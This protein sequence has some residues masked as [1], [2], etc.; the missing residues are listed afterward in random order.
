[1][2]V[3]EAGW[4]LAFGSVKKRLLTSWWIILQRLALYTLMKSSYA[5]QLASI[6]PGKNDTFCQ[7][8]I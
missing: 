3:S 7:L 8:A 2:K 5:T 6:K 1:M 4:Q